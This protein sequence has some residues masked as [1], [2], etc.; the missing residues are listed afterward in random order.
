[1]ARDALHVLAF[2]TFISF[3]FGA[4]R[5]THALIFLKR[6][7]FFLSAFSENISNS[8]KFPAFLNLVLL[9]ILFPLF[10]SVL[11]AIFWPE[12]FSIYLL[13][14]LPY[15]LFALAVPR[16]HLVG[17]RLIFMGSRAHPVYTVTLTARTVS[18][19]VDK[20]VTWLPLLLFCIFI[21]AA[22]R[23]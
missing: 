23:Q 19:Y 14:C 10:G 9:G 22:V 21:V 12:Y 7:Q 11:M 17:G 5:A 20:F 18:Q 2:A 8:G 15:Y 13:L 4:F 1:M 3:F 16:E 6:R